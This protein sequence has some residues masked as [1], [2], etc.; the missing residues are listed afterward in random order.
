MEKEER[1][2][3]SNGGAEPSQLQLIMLSAAGFG[4]EVAYTVE[5]GYAIPTMLSTGLPETFAS[6][7]W[8]VGPVLGL[9][10]QGYLGS[11][12]DKSTC[13]WGKRRPFILGL[14]VA[15]C[16]SLFLFPYG[17]TLSVKLLGL[18][19]KSARVF[20]MTFT[21]FTFVMMD[22]SLDAVQSP[23]RA[24]LLDSVSSEQSEKANYTYTA[25]LTC[26]ALL[27]SL[28]AGIPWSKV[29]TA[30]EDDSANG[31]VE[32]IF[33]VS[34]G[35]LAVCILFCLNSV[36]ER[37]AVQVKALQLPVSISKKRLVLLPD[38]LGGEWKKTTP[39]VMS[40][41]DLNVR[42]GPQ[43]EIVA[44]AR[45]GVVDAHNGGSYV[46]S[47]PATVAKTCK[48]RN[49]C[50]KLFLANL[51]DTVYGTFLFSKYMSKQFLQL[52]LAVF[53]NW[54]S[55]LSMFL[56]FTS[57]VGEVVYGGSAKA[58]TG[59]SREIF[60]FGVRVGCLLFLFQDVVSLVCSLS[61]QW[62]SKAVGVRRLYLGGLGSYVIICG[63]T[64]VYPSLMNVIL[65][66]GITG[67]M[68]ANLL[69]LPYS[70][71]THYKVTQVTR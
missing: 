68:Y 35:V 21:A 1:T 3:P 5:A 63:V 44:T 71:L 64:A 67:L 69:S 24:Y 18:S 42:L 41:A 57:F 32:V 54:V 27:G 45:K 70:L 14:T 52:W 66:Q 48:V 53:L 15:A 65:L 20:V 11:A 49:S 8:G 28:L 19:E 50:P 56:F 12:S 4:V 23:I 47:S 36:Q 62:L 22:F 17:E 29:V 25:L 33:S 30:N 46:F 59:E 16:L 51:Y 6:A 7:M 58:K 9:F 38:E 61:Y 60:S 2:R 34:A 26:G 37:N 13:V 39:K 10:F 31:Q 43:L 55:Y 40:Q